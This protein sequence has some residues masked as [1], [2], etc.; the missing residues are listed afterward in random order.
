MMNWLYFIRVIGILLLFLYLLFRSQRYFFWAAMGPIA[1]WKHPGMRRFGRLV[2]QGIVAAF[3]LALLLSFAATHTQW[4]LH[5]TKFAGLGVTWFT[6]C[7]LSYGSICLVRAVGWIFVWRG[8]H[9]VSPAESKLE[10]AENNWP[11]QQARRD[12][13]RRAA[14]FAGALPFAGAAYGFLIARKHYTV[15]R[16]EIPIANLP[17]ALDGMQIAQ[18]SD[19]HIGGFMT[20]E[21]VRRAVDMTNDLAADLS[22]VTG[23]LVT[24]AGDPLEACV[25][26]VSRLH[27]PLGVW[28]CNGNHEIYARA[29][30]RAAALFQAAGM[31]MLRHENAEV[32]FRGEPFNL[33]GVDYQRERTT[34]GQHT[35]MLAGV[36]PLV[37]G[38]VPN[39]LLSHNPNSF[40]RAA[41]LGIDLSLAGHTHGG[42]VRIEIVDHSLSPARFLTPYVAGF[43]SLAA[44]HSV[45]DAAGAR[46]SSHPFFASGVVAA[47]APRGQAPQERAAQAASGNRLSHIY[48]NRGLGTVG[49]PVRF[50]VPP[51]I[52]L[53][54]LRRA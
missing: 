20:R 44:G 12:F 16:I 10:S 14:A 39:I 50:D 49:A 2:L 15:R 27:A 40:P 11:A 1:R 35:L 36:E 52:T 8:T 7:L 28:G 13:V 29:E 47:T 18:V 5:L 21:S 30:A 25:E 19:I 17:S 42:Q 43:Y 33:I 6:A 31:R 9:G 53:L 34:L 41:Q 51:E 22:V 4:K 45:E 48:V 3:V 26:E 54:V 38:D 24:S 46:D 23:D 37:R 32:R